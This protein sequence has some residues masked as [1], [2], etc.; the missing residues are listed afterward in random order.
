MLKSSVPK[1]SCLVILRGGMGRPYER[2]TDDQQRLWGLLTWP[3][4]PRPNTKR[5]V[6]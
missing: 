1:I 4:N 2:E 5:V 6:V 3:S